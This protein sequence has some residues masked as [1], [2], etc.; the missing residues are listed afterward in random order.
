MPTYT[1]KCPKCGEFNIYLKM[2][3]SS[4][5]ECPTCQSP[6]KRVFQPQRAIFRGG[7][8]SNNYQRNYSFLDANKL[9]SG[10]V[11]AAEAMEEY[12]IKRWG[13]K[14]TPQQILGDLHREFD[15]EATRISNR[16]EV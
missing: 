16:K 13:E 9:A 12:K 4:L 5:E 10:K 15:N 2:S 14:A 3:S 1:F 7:L 11:T 6:V 8:P